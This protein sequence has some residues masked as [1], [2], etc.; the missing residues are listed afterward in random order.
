[1][2]GF[3]IGNLIM[4]EGTHALP[5]TNRSRLS[6]TLPEGVI[7]VANNGGT[8]GIAKD[9][10][11]T[12][13]SDCSGG[14]DVM[15]I[16]ENVFCSACPE[17][18]TES[19]LG[20]WGDKEEIEEIQQSF[21]IG[22][23]NNGGFIDLNQGITFASEIPTE[24]RFTEP[25]WDVLIKTPQVAQ[26]FSEFYGGLWPNGTP[27][28]NRAKL[29]VVNVFGTYVRLY[30][31]ASM[32]TSARLG[33]SIAMAN[34]V[35]C[36]CSSGTGGCTQEDITKGEGEEAIK[37]GDKCIAGGCVSCTMSGIQQVD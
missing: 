25:A 24:N 4:P 33:P 2:G 13:T 26:A 7:Y 21:L 3:Q 30:V 1:M 28:F 29:A 10:T 8:L 6:F 20:K 23:G 16:G 22:D 27:D 12:C 32:A 35:S 5:S 17:G 9:G 18:S 34:E 19:C 31:P 14:C 11:Y 15:S 37:I 36:G